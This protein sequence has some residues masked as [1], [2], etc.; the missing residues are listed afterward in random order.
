MKVALV[1]LQPLDN[2][3]GMQT[4]IKVLSSAL[5]SKGIEVVIV[6]PK[7]AYINSKKFYDNA[8]HSFDHIILPK[9]ASTNPLMRIRLFSSINRDNIMC[10]MDKMGVDIIDTYYPQ[11]GIKKENPIPIVY[12]SVSGIDYTIELLKLRQFR[13]SSLFLLNNIVEHCYINSVDHFIIENTIQKDRLIHT[14]GIPES[15]VTI[16]PTGINENH[17]EKSQMSRIKDKEKITLMYSGRLSYYK[18]MNELLTAYRSISRLCKRCELWIFGDGPMMNEMITY[19]KKNN[20][21]SVHFGGRISQEENIKQV[22]QCDIFIHPSYI[23]SLPSAIIEAMAL[24]KPVIST[25]VGAISRDLIVND[26]NGILIPPKNADKLVSAVLDLID[27][28]EKQ[29]IIG[30]N[31]GK[32]VL[33]Y[34]HKNMINQTIGVY[35]KVLSEF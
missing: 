35:K 28:P 1:C 3:G 18:G 15:K 31:A 30:K 16:A 29:E 24:K 14:Y 6:Q 11:I 5:V 27:Q 4:R 34:T 25:S 22:S 10:S 17:V 23:E 33:H 32:S 2:L 13:Y 8:L 19:C 20:L 21:N 26:Y 12:T 9:T 7:D